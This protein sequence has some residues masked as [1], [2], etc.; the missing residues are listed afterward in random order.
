MRKQ[1][2][3]GICGNRSDH[4]ASR[5]GVSAQMMCAVRIHM[6]NESDLDVVC[7]ATAGAFW[8]SD[9]QDK[10]CDG[11]NGFNWTLPISPENE[12]STIL[13]LSQT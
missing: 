5:N 12:N 2:L 1:T 13:A 7:P 10:R 8:T 3:M 6:L 9:G 4:W 11:G